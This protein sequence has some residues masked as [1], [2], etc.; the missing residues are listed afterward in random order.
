MTGVSVP[1]LDSA[2]ILRLAGSL[3]PARTAVPV[4]RGQRMRPVSRYP[5]PDPADLG[6]I[7]KWI[8]ETPK[9]TAID[10][11][12]GAGWLSLGLRD[13]GF[14]VLAGADSDAF[15]AETHHANLGGL[16]YLG[17]LTEPEDFLNH[18]TAWGIESVDLLAGG[19]PCQPFS[20][21]GRSKIRSLV[22]ARVR[23]SDDA[24][25]DLWQSFVR[26]AE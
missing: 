22:E 14:S 17:D 19:V 13:A 25:V 10:L 6:S 1:K 26:I 24:R 9:P 2:R 7:C 12:C 5:G 16:S 11:F 21:A 8:R 23:S 15:A 4:R 3:L 18:L 20:R